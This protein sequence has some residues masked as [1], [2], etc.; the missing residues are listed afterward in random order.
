LREVGVGA[1]VINLFLG[2]I[3]AAV[4]L[5][6]ALSFGLGTQRVAERELENVITALR[7]KDK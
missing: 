2:I 5:A 1:D 7:D 6:L 4:G 3:L